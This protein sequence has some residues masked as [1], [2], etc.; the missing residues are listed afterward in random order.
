ML[1]VVVALTD[2]VFVKN[3]RWYTSNHIIRVCPGQTRITDF[4]WELEG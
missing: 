4:V 3:N 2:D 1:I